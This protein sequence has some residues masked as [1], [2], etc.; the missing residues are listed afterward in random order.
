VYKMALFQEWHKDWLKPWVHYI[1][2]SLQG[3]DWLESV[4]YFAGE[5]EG[6][7]QA[8]RMALQG[9]DWARKVLR[10]DDLEVWFFRLLLE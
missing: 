10:N 9:R 1:P 8:P 3:D 4:R 2:L 5:E 6:K 7:I